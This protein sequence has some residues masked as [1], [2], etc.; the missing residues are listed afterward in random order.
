M[1]SDVESELQRRGWRCKQS[2]NFLFKLLQ[3]L[4]LSQLYLIVE[5]CN[6]VSHHYVVHVFLLSVVVNEDLLLYS[7]E[8]SNGSFSNAMLGRASSSDVV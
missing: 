8:G 1:S 7:K 3:D 6:V 5:E 4:L 2:L